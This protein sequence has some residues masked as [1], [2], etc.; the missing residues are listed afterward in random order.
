MT[1]NTAFFIFMEWS[2]EKS[3]RLVEIKSARTIE[4]ESS[5]HGYRH[6]FIDSSVS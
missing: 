2:L 4:P 5:R 1:G 3:R 6:R